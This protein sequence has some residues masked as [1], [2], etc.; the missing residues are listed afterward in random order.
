[1]NEEAIFADAIIAA[2][3]EVKAASLEGFSCSYGIAIAVTWSEQ[4]QTAS[5]CL[6]SAEAVIRRRR[7]TSK[8]LNNDA[9]R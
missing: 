9:L 6:R 2:E 1:M 4:L 7:A 8:E 3:H 5:D